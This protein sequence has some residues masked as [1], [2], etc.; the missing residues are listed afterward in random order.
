MVQGWADRYANNMPCTTQDLALSALG[1]WCPKQVLGTWHF[2]DNG[3]GVTC[4]AQGGHE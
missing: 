4:P 1:N 2:L 3:T